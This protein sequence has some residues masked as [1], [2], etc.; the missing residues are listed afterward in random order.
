[1]TARLKVAIERRAS[2]QFSRSI[3]RVHF[4]VRPASLQV[5]ALPRYDAVRRDDDGADDRI[6]TGPAA[7]AFSQT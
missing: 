5:R 4:G 2:S 7:A 3:K 1:M 6:R